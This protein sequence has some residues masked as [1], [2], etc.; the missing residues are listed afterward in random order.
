MATSSDDSVARA[1]RW[2]INPLLGFRPLD[3]IRRQLALWR[4]IRE[5]MGDTPEEIAAKQK[6]IGVL[7]RIVVADTEAEAHAI[8]NAGSL[9]FAEAI[10]SLNTV[11]GESTPR[12]HETLLADGRKVLLQVSD[13]EARVASA[14]NAETGTIAG[15]KP[16][17]IEQLYELQETGVGHVLAGFGGRGVPHKEARANLEMIASDILPLFNS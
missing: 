8:T 12:V 9:Q 4:S 1:A 13:E 5:E 16:H 10:R 2:G 15:T 14:K 17:V 7:R 6:E 3:V 11:S